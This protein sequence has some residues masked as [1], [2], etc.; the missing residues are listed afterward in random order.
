MSNDSIPSCCCKDFVLW[1]CCIEK[2]LEKELSVSKD[3]RPPKPR[4][5]SH[6]EQNAVRYTAG[7][8]IKKVIK[9]RKH[10]HDIAINE[11]LNGLLQDKSDIVD[12][13][14]SSEH[15]LKAT[16]RGGLYYIT[17][18]AF[19]LFI[20]VEVFTYD[21]LSQMEQVNLDELYT[22]ACRDPDIIRVWRECVLDIEETEKTTLLLDIIKEWVKIRGHSIADMAME[23]HKKK[24]S[25]IAKKKAL[26]VELRRSN[27]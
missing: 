15:W 8:V 18:L 4:I 22:S 11:C 27:N 26:R 23:Q 19:E 20:E 12:N 5:L 24:K 25:E 21:K 3:Q 1:Q 7:S 16:D 14:D 10:M 6:V 17:D 13:Q 9:K 2:L